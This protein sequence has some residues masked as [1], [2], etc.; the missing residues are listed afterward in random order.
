MIETSSLTAALAP[1][2]VEPVMRSNAERFPRPSA[3]PPLDPPVTLDLSPNA[4][5]TSG[6]AAGDA[7]TDDAKAAEVETAAAQAAEAPEPEPAS[8]TA[9][10]RPDLDS[11]QIVFQVVGRDGTVVEQLPSAAFLR[12]QTYAREAEAAGKA[13]IGTSVARTA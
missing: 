13:E 5:R 6:A 11:R 4:L 8:L 1:V 10:F 3:D 2:A 7:T 9:R 12:A